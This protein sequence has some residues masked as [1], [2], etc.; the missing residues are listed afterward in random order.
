MPK[1]SLEEEK[2]AKF[3]REGC[4]LILLNCSEIVVFDTM[5]KEVKWK[6]ELA[7]EVVKV[8]WTNYPNTFAAVTYEEV[9]II[10]IYWRYMVLKK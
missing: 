6:L 4:A 9:K 7:E 5:R 8:F 2:H 1:F 10:N 3:D